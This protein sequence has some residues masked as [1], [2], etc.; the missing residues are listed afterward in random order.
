GPVL[1][2]HLRARY[3]DV[4]LIGYDSGF[5]A[6]CLTAT[7][8]PAESLL[9]RQYF[10]DVREFPAD[11]LEGIDAV[12]HLAAISNDSMSRRFE[13]VTGD[14][15]FRASVTIAEAAERAGVQ[16]FVFASSCSIYGAGGEDAKRET[17]E[18]QPLTAYA[19]SK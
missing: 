9:D 19:R 1:V 2:S 14:I 18:V 16:N 3:A 12:V 13:A 17:D 7:T 4:E 5:F 15:N 11:L 8:T 6:H 10:G